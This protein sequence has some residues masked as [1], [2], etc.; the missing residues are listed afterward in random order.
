MKIIPKTKKD[1]SWVNFTPKEITGYTKKVIEMISRDVES[2]KDIPKEKRN[3][4][5]TVF[6]INEIGESNLE[7]SPVSFLSYVSTDE[8]TRKAS[9]EFQE[10]VSKKSIDISF[11]RKLYEAFKEFDMNKEKLSGPEIRLYEDIKNGFE[12]QGFHLPPAKQRELKVIK[13]RLTT[14]GIKFSK[15]IDSYHDQ[16]LCSRDELRGLPENYISNLKIDK[17]TGKYIVTLAYPELGPFMK[18]A[19]SDKKRKE[20]SDKSAQRGGKENL[21]ILKEILA[22]RTKQAK[23]L[24]YPNFVALSA[25]ELIAKN[26][27]N[28][29]DFLVGTIEKLRP[30]VDK[31]LKELQMF[32]SKNYPG[33]KLQY[34]NMAYFSTKMREA[35]FSYDQKEV[36][37]YFEIENVLGKMKQIFGKLFGVSFRP[38][39]EL[40]LWHKDAEM[41]DVVEK[42]KVI[43]HF[44]LDLYPRKDKY[45]HMGCSPLIPGKLASF[46]N[47]KE[48]LAPVSVIVGNFPISSKANPSLLSVGEVETIFHEFGHAIHGVLTRAEISSQAGTNVL[49]DFVEMPSQLFENWTKDK[50]N[51]RFISEH[52]K[53]GK[54]MASGLIDKVLKSSDF[55]K[56][57][58]Y[59]YTFV[60]SLQ[61]FEMHTDKWNIEPLRLSRDFDKRYSQVPSSPKSLFPAGWGHMVGYEAKYYSYMWA[62]VYSYDVFSR[63]K[64]EGIMNKKV[65]LELRRKILE[66]GDSEDPLKIM[67]EFLGRKPNNKAFLEALK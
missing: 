37:E 2:I 61:D 28:I 48:Y 25:K 34:F 30:R 5:N 17:K 43:G 56:A 51:L 57:H 10:T 46:R 64:K 59:Y 24:G 63:F 60:I 40:P 55:M 7:D 22:L 50:E 26:P 32:I 33:K 45:S 31:E 27:E 53:T 44:G 4:E 65:G 16:I 8:K 38:N 3:F 11:D 49:H 39:Q 62:L 29:K 14:L 42:G 18:F 35:E 23:L 66:K 20:L 52:F 6:A 41:F 58:Q 54:K 21:L 67:T 19:E 15:N 13:K 12:D 47:K 36:K 9:R 1:F